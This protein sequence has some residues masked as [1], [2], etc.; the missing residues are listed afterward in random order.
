MSKITEAQVMEALSHVIE[1]ELHRDLVTLDMVKN[2]QINGG[3]VNFTIMLTTPACPLKHKMEADANAAL[4]A[5]PG[6]EKVNISFDSNIPADARLMSKMNIGVKNAIAVASGKGGVGKSTMSANLAL[7][8]ALDGAKVGLLDADVYGP[9]IPMMMGIN[10][11]PKG[12][13]NKIIPPEAY[14]VKI[15]SMG[16]L[17]DANQPVIWRGPMIHNALRQ[18]LQDVEWGSLDYLVVDLPPGTGDASLSLA[19]SLSLTGA[20]IVTTPQQVA[21]S[22]VVRGVAMFQQLNVPILGVIEN[23]SYFVAPDTGHRYDIFGHGGGAAMAKEVGADFLGEV[24]LE[25]Q[26]RMGGDEGSPIVVRAP[27]SVAAQ[28]I[29]AV[30]QKVAA[31]ISV[32]NLLHSPRQFQADP[33][34]SILN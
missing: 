24:P 19:Q 12:H 28:A 29:R 16:F 25:P 23:M 32:Q 34:L 2:V 4:L 10:E 21:L 15:M 30:A 3:Q 7:S 5:I 6:V 11:R 14:N 33:T 13:N 26:V 8:L 22:D 31:A 1:P 9:N 18:F 20:V 27:E 17:V